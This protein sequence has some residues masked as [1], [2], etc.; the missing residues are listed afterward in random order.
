MAE[1]AGLDLVEISPNAAP[2]VCKILDYGKFKFEQQKKA[3][4]ARKKQKTVEVKEIKLRPGI[5]DHD[6]EVK[7][8]AVRRF[9][10]EGDKVKITLR[11][12]GR[13]M[14]HQELG[15]KLL[16]RVKAEMFDISKIES[17]PMLEG[18]QMI[19]VL[20]PK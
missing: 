8:K 16:E 5:D 9:F 7:M 11:F 17:E 14:A 4:E 10:E 20:A 6:Y 18:R 2:P 13:E 15:I 12:R 1:E 3:A 19:M